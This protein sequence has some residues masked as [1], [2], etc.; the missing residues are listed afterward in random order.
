MRR[1][2]TAVAAAIVACLIHSAANAGIMVCNDF[3]KRIEVALAQEEQSTVSAQGW[4]AVEPRACR[5]VDFAL[6]GSMLYY[7]AESE[8]YKQGGASVRHQWGEAKRLFVGKGVF[9]F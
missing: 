1:L 8:T 5:D 3:H 7:R 9:K 6:R 4:W 2:A